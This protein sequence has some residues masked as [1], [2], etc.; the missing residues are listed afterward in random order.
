LV[1][2]YK[3]LSSKHFKGGTNVRRS[4][5]GPRHTALVSLVAALILALFRLAEAA[6]ID[7]KSASLSDVAAAIASAADGDIVTIPG[8]TATWTRTLQVRKA[9]TLQGAGVGVT[10]IKDGVQK[11]K[12]I[13]WTLAAGNASRLTGIEFQDGG[14]PNGNPY[15]MNVLGSNTNGATFRWDHCAWNGVKGVPI[16]NTV[17]GVV[18]HIAFSN[19]S[20]TIWIYGSNWDGQENGDGSWAAPV[21]F[22]SSQ[23]LFIEDCTADNPGPTYLGQF[24]DAYAGARFVVRHCTL[25]G[26]IV[27]D[28][29]TESTGR[30]RGGR[31][32]EIYQNTF[33]GHNINSFFGGSRSSRVIVHDNTVVNFWSPTFFNLT[34]FRM[35]YPFRPWGGADGTNAWDVN[36]TARS[37]TG[38]AAGASSG[39]TVTVSG[40]PNWMPN[41]WVGYTLRRTTDNC[42]SHS[43]NFGEIV[44]STSNTLTYTG[45]G[46]YGSPPPMSLCAGDSLEIRK[47][48]YAL[49]QPGRGGG[50]LITGTPPVRPPQWNDQVTEPCYQWNNGNISFNANQKVIRAGEHYFNN[51]PMP[52]YTE[53]TYP[54]P[55]TKGLPPPEQTTRN[56]T[57]NSQHDA[58]KKRRP[59][60]GKKPERK[61]AKKTKESPTNEMAEDQE[62]VGN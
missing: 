27:G 38:A 49:D 51:T 32:M 47:V 1:Q 37:Y 58:H 23:F 4:T 40:N 19:G 17:I 48:D 42:N 54:H 57:A 34:C 24:T 28:H 16:F 6:T 7:A 3:V 31:A 30:E 18:D 21:N 12:L 36:R 29:G 61:K 33:D 25:G 59:W 2:L 22:G 5:P 60:G 14:R 9:I 43:I 46:G 26:L 20:L 52:G 44:S 11:G 56:A 39:T 10:I 50:S 53:F 8:G 13:D 62:N 35:F 45:N 15:V 55:L 41:Q